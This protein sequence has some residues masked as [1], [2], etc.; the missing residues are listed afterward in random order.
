[1]YHNT[2]GLGSLQNTEHEA[3][4]LLP[5]GIQKLKGFQLQGG[6]FAP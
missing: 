6:G 1:M 5:Q 3:K 2:W 4:L